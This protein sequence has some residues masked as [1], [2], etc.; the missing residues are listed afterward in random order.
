MDN[1]CAK[2][3]PYSKL[4]VKSYGKETIKCLQSVNC[5]LGDITLSQGHDIIAWNI[6][7][8]YLG[9]KEFRPGR[10]WLHVQCD[11]DLGDMTLGQGHDT[12]MGNREQLCEIL[13]R[14]NM[15]VR[16]Y[17]LDNNFYGNVFLRDGELP[18]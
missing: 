7:Q 2:Y 6:I 15:T 18:G 12:S 11:L 10:F 8:I 13:S 3:H 9:S 1:N 5:D 4:P 16:R 17:G 14:S